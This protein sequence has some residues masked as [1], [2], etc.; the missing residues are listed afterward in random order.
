M[1]GTVSSISAGLGGA[2]LLDRV[3]AFLTEHMAFTLP[4]QADAVTL[5]VA[6]THAMSVAECTPRL[7]IQSAEKQ[8]GKTRLLELLDLLCYKPMPVAS[9]SQ[10]AMY[11]VIED[12]VT[13]LIDEVDTVFSKSGGR[14]EDIRGILNAG[15]RRSGSVARVMGSEIIRYP[16]FAACALAGIGSLPDTVQDRSIVIRLK[17]RRKDQ[18]VAKLRRRDVEDE[19]DELRGALAEW[20]RRAGSGSYP[21]MPEV[22]SD[23]ASD[24]LE[25]LFVL[26]S[27]ASK[28]WLKRAEKASVTLSSQ[29]EDR[30]VSR[31]AMLLR[32]IEKVLRE[33]SGKRITSADLVVKLRGLDSHWDKSFE[34]REL[35]ALL[36]PFDIKPK[37]MRHAGQVVRG[38]EKNDFAD[39]FARYI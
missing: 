39:A 18:N 14:S 7:S 31:G 15:Y 37:T 36:Q 24:I 20:A 32:D 4:E 11:R 28:A 9:I 12:G 13:L 34:A 17:R 10:A 30:D 25:P 29:S 35:A 3:H 38:Y 1:T 5:W 23:R 21:K 27:H 2:G 26:A 16:V 33:H 8:S 19:C 22:L 6:H